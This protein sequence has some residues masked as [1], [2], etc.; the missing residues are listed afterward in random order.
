MKIKLT[1][2]AWPLVLIALLTWA[3]VG[4]FI[5]TV[6]SDETDRI[7]RVQSA[8]EAE[9]KEASTLRLRAIAQDTLLNRTQLDAIL[10]VDVISVVD[11]LEASGKAAGVKLVVSS[12]QPEGAPPLQGAG[13]AQVIG[14]GFVVEAQGKFSS[15]LHAAQLFETLPVPSKVGRLDIEHINVADQKSLDVWRMN[16][17]VH[18]LTT[19]ATPI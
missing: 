5:W 13:S 3:A 17:Q 16:V 7:T 12:V 6:L 1:H 15:L 18:T 10:D 19:S 4:V 2:I 8:Q 9:Q 14:T 11:M